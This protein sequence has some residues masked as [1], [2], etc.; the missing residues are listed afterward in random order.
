MKKIFVFYVIMSM[1]LIGVNAQETETGEIELETKNIISPSNVY[2]YWLDRLGE[3]A[4]LVFYIPFKEKR[5]EKY[6]SMSEERLQ[7]LKDLSDKNITK[8]HEGLR[9]DYSK[10]LEKIGNLHDSIK[11]LERKKEIAKMIAERVALH[12]ERL[13]EVKAQVPES[14]QSS[15]QKAID[16]GRERSEEFLE[17]VAEIQE[18]I[19]NGEIEDVEEEDDGNE[20]SKNSRSY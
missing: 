7:E 14:A 2:F 4:V 6:L 15:I 13:E 18:K 19:D 5:I 8:Y 20:T 11:K 9:N 3:G 17:R 16:K 12:V 10:Y 1:L